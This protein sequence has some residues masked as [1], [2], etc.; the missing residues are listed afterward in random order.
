MHNQTK[1]SI[2]LVLICSQRKLK[3]TETVVRI[4]ATE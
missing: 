3:Q 2:S 4:P 1:C